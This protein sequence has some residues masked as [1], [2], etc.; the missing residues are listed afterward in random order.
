MK[1]TLEER[2]EYGRRYYQ[3]H[4]EQMKKSQEKYRQAHPE[5]T[6]ENRIHVRNRQKKIKEQVFDILGRRCVQCGF[7]D[8]RALQV[9]HV[10]GG[11]NQ[12]RKK[13]SSWGSYR[14]VITANG[15]GYQVLCANCNQIKR[16][17]TTFD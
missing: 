16:H 7:S 15:E 12:H 11:G 17:K 6:E 8:A 14:D 3:T 5:R 1:Q 4:K 9:D 10:N 13:R 2:R